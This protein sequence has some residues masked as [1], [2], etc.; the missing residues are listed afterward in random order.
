MARRIHGQN[1]YI[2]PRTEMV[3]A[4]F[5]SHPVAANMVNDVYALPAYEAMADHL[6]N[7]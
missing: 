3:V 4:R 7:T 6:R 1:I 5:A 2:D